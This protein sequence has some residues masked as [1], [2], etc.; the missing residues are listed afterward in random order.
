MFDNGS[1]YITRGVGNRIPLDIQIFIWQLIEDLKDT[2]G[3]VDYLQVF[4]ISIADETEETVRIIHSQ[5]VQQYKKIWIVKA[6]EPCDNEKIFV[7]DD[8]THST[9]L[10]AE[11]Y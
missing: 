7:I 9:M 1:R 10:L 2:V 8:D 11:E 6:S 5:E 3:E 4:D